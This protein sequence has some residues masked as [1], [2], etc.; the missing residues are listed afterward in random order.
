M[1]A[2]LVACSLVALSLAVVP[3][4][5]AAPPCYP[6]QACCET[7][8]VPVTWRCIGVDDLRDCTVDDPLACIR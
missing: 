2:L 7:G 1:K 8:E 4:A 3:A 6:D 5:E